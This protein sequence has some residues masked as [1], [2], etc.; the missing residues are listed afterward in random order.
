[1]ALDVLPVAVHGRWVKHT[2][3]GSLPLPEREP[4]PDNRWQG[5][6]IDDALYLADTDETAWAE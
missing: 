2:Y 1:M 3:P 6:D 5:G 4:P